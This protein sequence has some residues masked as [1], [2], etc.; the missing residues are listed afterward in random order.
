MLFSGAGLGGLRWCSWYW[1]HR[2]SLLLVLFS[3]AL[4]Y[5]GGWDCVVDLMPTLL[6]PSKFELVL[7]I[8]IWE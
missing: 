4:L 1:A 3:L 8:A 7:V 5:I 6:F 2:D